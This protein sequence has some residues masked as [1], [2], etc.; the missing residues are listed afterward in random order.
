MYITNNF[1]LRWFGSRKMALQLVRGHHHIHLNGICDGS[2]QSHGSRADCMPLSWS[3][4]KKKYPHHP[5]WAFEAS[6]RLIYY[7]QTGIKCKYTIYTTHFGSQIRNERGAIRACVA[8]FTSMHSHIWI[9]IKQPLEQV[10]LAG[11]FSPF[12]MQLLARRWFY[13]LE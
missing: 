13:S 8:K 9:L 1:L 10:V 6:Q 2:H 12:G 7:R 3:V 5:L 11:A 4:R